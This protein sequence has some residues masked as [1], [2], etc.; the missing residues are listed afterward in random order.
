MRTGAFQFASAPV[1][2]RILIEIKGNDT[3]MTSA[4]LLALASFAGVVLLL[5][6]VPAL[7]NLLTVSRERNK[8]KKRR[9]KPRPPQAS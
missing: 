6:G 2:N 3:K 5:F 8:Q 7:A 9:R 1:R 4:L